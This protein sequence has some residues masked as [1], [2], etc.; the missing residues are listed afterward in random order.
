MITEEILTWAEQCA[1]NLTGRSISRKKNV[2]ADQLSFPDQVL[3]TE[4]SPPPQVFEDVFK[5]FGRPLVDFFNT[6]PN[7][8]L[9]FYV[10]PV[11]D[12]MAWKEDAFHHSWNCLHSYA[13]TSFPLLR[14]NLL[15]VM[16]SW[17]LYMILVAPL[18]HRKE[19]FAKFLSLLGDVFSNH[20]C[21]RTRL[22]NLMF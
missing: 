8:K 12:P 13:F 18:W 4:W 16:I 1:V 7:V 5:V 22:F 10:F 9:P 11:P 2:L 19:W 6:R 20:S 3:P 21:C 17:N 14:Q 15:R